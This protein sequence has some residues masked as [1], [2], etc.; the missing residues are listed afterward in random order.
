MVYGTHKFY[1]TTKT[2]HVKSNNHLVELTF[3]NNI[4]SA[5]L[6]KDTRSEEDRVI[7]PQMFNKGVLLSYKEIQELE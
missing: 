5:I 4:I 7:K 1:L 6:A 3:T 2:N